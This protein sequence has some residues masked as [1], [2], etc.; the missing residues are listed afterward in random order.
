MWSADE[1]SYRHEE[2]TRAIIGAFF[3]VH[4]E[5]CYGFLESVYREAMGIALGGAG[6]QAHAEFAM[7][8]RFRG[9]TVGEFKAELVVNGLVVV[10]LKAVRSLAPPHEAQMLNYLRASVLEVG[11]LFN[12]GPQPQIRRFASSNQRK[13][14]A[15]LLSL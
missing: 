11:L 3:E 9:Q 7:T 14:P 15:G 1:R 2:I 12:F 8:A 4:N 5:L 13:R 10:E 6:L